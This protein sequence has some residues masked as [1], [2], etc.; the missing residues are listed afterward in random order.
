M[1]HLLE[2]HGWL[3]RE[4][5]KSGSPGPTDLRVAIYPSVDADVAVWVDTL[6]GVP[7]EADGRFTVVLGVGAPLD[8]TIFD[9][10]PVWVSAVPARSADAEGDTL[11][12]PLVGG[13]VRLARD[14]ADLAAR[15]RR[16]E[17][18]AGALAKALRRRTVVLLRRIRGIEA[19]GGAEGLPARLATVEQRLEQLAGSDGRLERL[20][21]EIED[22]VGNDGDIIDLLERVEQLEGKGPAPERF[23]PSL[24][25]QPKLTPHV[26]ERIELF[27]KRLTAIESKPAIPLPTAEALHVV[28]KAGDVMT[29]GLVINRGGLDVL[30]GGIKCRGADVN[31]LEAT[32]YVKAPKLIGDA[33]EVRGD[34]TVDSTKRTLQIRHIEGRAGSGRKDGG[35]VLNGRSGAVVEVGIDGEMSDGLTV[36]GPVRAPS[37]N[38]PGSALAIAFQSGGDFKSGEVVGVNDQGHLI[39]TRD[40]YDARVI[41]V[42]G[43]HPAVVL[44]VGPERK[45]LVVIGG[46]T[47]CRVDATGGAIRAGDLLVAS[48]ERGNARRADDRDRAFG[49]VI[50]KALGA[51]A[52]GAGELNVLVFAR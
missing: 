30:S 32:L 46:I 47:R 9:G 3:R 24:N 49:A 26:M 7:V 16:Q 50:G 23:I 15:V 48:G 43:E 4:D 33:L 36:H 22:L 12:V 38:L 37:V 17:T 5:G 29:G 1:I 31:S 51:H 34:I 27:D 25:P 45:V 20:E 8:P 44:G 2:F 39:H 10:E 13:A 35:L 21:D 42:V 6:R 18:D 40:A 52:E 41:G 11:R 14:V 28:K 19:G